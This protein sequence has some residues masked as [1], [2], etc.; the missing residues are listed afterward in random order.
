[1]LRDAIGGMTDDP[2]EENSSKK[3]EDEGRE[4][5]ERSA[6]TTYVALQNGKT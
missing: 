6:T 4:G 2:M 3:Q 1:M 5:R